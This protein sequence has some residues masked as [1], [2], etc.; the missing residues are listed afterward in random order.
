[1]CSLCPC[2]KPNLYLR[3]LKLNLE[4]ALTSDLTGIKDRKWLIF[5]SILSQSPLSAVHPEA[6]V[7]VEVSSVSGESDADREEEIIP[8]VLDPLYVKHQ[9]VEKDFSNLMDWWVTF[10]PHIK[11]KKNSFTCQTLSLLVFL[12]S[13]QSFKELPRMLDQAETLKS[14]DSL[15]FAVSVPSGN[16]STTVRQRH[17][18]VNESETTKSAQQWVLTLSRQILR[19]KIILADKPHPF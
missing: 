11:A 12:P 18:T 13:Y 10:D 1:M 6:C 4:T 14:H 9:H 15:D 2:W 7:G 16:R 17:R 3:C 19:K 8:F 5:S